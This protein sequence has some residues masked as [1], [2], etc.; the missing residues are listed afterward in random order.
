MQNKLILISIYFIII[1][2]KCIE[3]S[4]MAEG[5]TLEEIHRKQEQMQRSGDEQ[6]REAEKRHKTHQKRPQRNIEIETS[7]HAE[8]PSDDGIC[9]QIDVIRFTGATLLSESDTASLSAPY[10]GRCLGM[11]E[12]NELVRDVTNLYIARG[13]VTTR[14]S[15]P[16]QDLAS[17]NLEIRVVE[18]VVEDVRLND[19][20]RP[21]RR[22]VAM[23]F[24][25]VKIG[26]PLNL[27]DIEQGVERMNRLPSSDARVRIEPGARPGTSIVVI[28]DRPD[29]SWR[30]AVGLDNSGQEITG[31]TKCAASLA[32]D[33]P[34]GLNDMLT[35]SASVDARALAGHSRPAS[36]GYSGYYS[37]PYGPWTVTGSAS[38]S[39]Y[40]ARLDGGGA[41]YLNSGETTVWGLDVNRVIHRSEESATSAG[42]N[43]NVKDVDNYL[44]SERLAAGSYN[45][46]VL[47]VSLEH[48]RSFFGGTLDLRAGYDIGLPVLGA[49]RD[50]TTARSAPKAEFQKIH[51]SGGWNRH[52]DTALRPLTFSTQASAQWSPDTLYSSERLDLGGLHTVRGFQRES[53]AGDNGGYVRSE[54][55]TPLLP[56]ESLPVD[57]VTAIGEPRLYAGYDA[58]FIHWDED[59]AYERGVLQGAALGLRTR[60]GFIDADLCLSKPLDAPAFM[61]NRDWE[62][63]WSISGNF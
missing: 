19:N 36:H 26:A 11:N 6:R 8:A 59:D 62:F 32:V 23:T 48:S 61:N 5:S 14:A 47:G 52:V 21:D 42:L 7:G 27:R 10:T 28:E 4:D 22:R 51:A 44:E 46:T 45:L 25:G 30:V 31:R 50:M 13:Y 15:V 12:I 55:S 39:E 43:L 54:V 33:N 40:R 3:T 57:L 41:Q 56:Q 2:I 35:L 49:G 9:V 53:L 18:G 37:V 34:I 24:P 20:S 1:S 38:F 63:Y 29:T 17:G 58:G 16:V 60:G